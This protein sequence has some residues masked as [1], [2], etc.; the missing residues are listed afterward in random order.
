MRRMGYIAFIPKIQKH[1]GKASRK[2]NKNGKKFQQSIKTQL[3][4]VLAIG[5]TKFKNS[6]ERKI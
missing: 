3:Y 5:N 6:F 1:C 4:G 2:Q